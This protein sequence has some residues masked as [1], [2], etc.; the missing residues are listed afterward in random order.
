MM[1]TGRREDR[2][3]DALVKI[4]KEKLNWFY[5]FLK[6]HLGVLFLQQNIIKVVGYVRLVRPIFA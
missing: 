1:C 3:K 4:G 6:K 2:V 5:A